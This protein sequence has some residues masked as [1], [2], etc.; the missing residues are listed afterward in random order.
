[1][2]GIVTTAIPLAQPA[3]ASR[4]RIEHAARELESQFAHLMIKSMRAATPGD[5]MGGETAYRDMYDQRLSREI[6]KGRGLGLQSAIVRQL[7]GASGGAGASS[8]PLPLRAA[9]AAMR[10]E[11]A[12]AALP[13]AP[14]DLALA[15]SSRGNSLQGV[16]LS[17]SL[18]PLATVTA[19]TAASVY[20]AQ[21]C[22]D[23]ELECSSQETFVTSIWPAAQQ[24]ADELGVSPKALVA[25]AALETN[26]GRSM[27]GHASNQV[28]NNLFGI[29]ASR[30]WEGDTVSAGTHEFKD[31]QRKDERAAFR[32]YSSLVDSFRDYARLIRTDR[33]EQARA[34][35]DNIAGYVQALQRAGYAT[36]PQYAAKITSIANGETLNRALAK[37]ASVPE[38]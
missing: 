37:L 33:Y 38:G 23:G 2:Q 11:H 10:I 25:Q 5:P 21:E 13:L 28:S 17:P 12:P 30:N 8:G 32:S 6:T 31:G 35:G 20:A 3:T 15:P 14:G 9:P 24:T 16:R 4:E 34:A 27:I 29:K 18:P 7:Q 1:M 19:R 36:D 22:G 26:W